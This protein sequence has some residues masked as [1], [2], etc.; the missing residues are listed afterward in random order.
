VSVK[1]RP[2]IAYAVSVLSR[3]MAC[4]KVPYLQAAKRVLRYVA[5]DP[6]AGIYFR[7][8]KASERRTLTLSCKLYS[9]SDFAGYPIMRKSTSGMVRL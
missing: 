6:G 9:D 4:H 3:F 5:Q 8:R 7:G 1:T 2:D